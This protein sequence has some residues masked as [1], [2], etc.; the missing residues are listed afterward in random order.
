MS[1]FKHIGFAGLMASVAGPGEG[2]GPRT[3]RATNRL[4]GAPHYTSEKPLTK[5]QKRRA[6]GRG[7]S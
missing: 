5:R 7:K 4:K 6:R 1:L 3:W 2:P